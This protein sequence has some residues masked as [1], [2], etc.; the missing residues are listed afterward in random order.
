MLILTHVT[1]L[2]RKISQEK[3]VKV[4]FLTNEKK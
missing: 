1:C 2:L 4:I 3:K